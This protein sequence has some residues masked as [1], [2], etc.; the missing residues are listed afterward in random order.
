MRCQISITALSLIFAAMLGPMFAI[1]T[2]GLRELR[3]LPVTNRDLWRTTWVVATVV[4]AGVLL[5]TK[6][7]SALLVAAFGGSPKVSAEAML[8]SAVYDFTW[9][10]AMLP[11]FPLLVFASAAPLAVEPLRRRW[12]P[13]GSIV[14]HAGLLRAADP[15]ERRVAGTRWRVHIGDDGSVDRRSGD[16]LRRAGVDTAARRAGRRTRP[17][18]ARSRSRRS[19]ELGHGLPIA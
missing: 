5:A 9:A 8:L 17:G 6:T 14:A 7:I 3:H 19:R 15:G 10:G 18:S 1:A 16:R 11:V 12:Q 2:M 4:P 13:A